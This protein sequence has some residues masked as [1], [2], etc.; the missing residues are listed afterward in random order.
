MKPSARQRQQRAAAKR[1]RRRR[2]KAKAPVPRKS[3]CLKCGYKTP[4]LDSGGFTRCANCGS[5]KT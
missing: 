1:D 3:H 4:D 2:R 5:V